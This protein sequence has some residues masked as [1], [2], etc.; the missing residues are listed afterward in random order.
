MEENKE[1]KETKEINNSEIKEAG[2]VVAK[3]T[4][5]NTKTAESNTTNTTT[6]TN[7]KNNRYQRDYRSRNNNNIQVGFR[8]RICK[9]CAFDAQKPSYKNPESLKRYISERGKIL[10]QRVT[11]SCAKHQRYIAREIKRA[12]ILAYLPFDRK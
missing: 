7:K 2:A 3:A 4:E 6:A 11:G 5:N 1:K 10:P 9:L 8:K 12:R